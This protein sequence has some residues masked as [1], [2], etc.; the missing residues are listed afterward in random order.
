MLRPALFALLTLAPAAALVGGRAGLHSVSARSPRSHRPLSHRTRADGL[1]V[2]SRPVQS[3][4]ARGASQGDETTGWF[5]DA[6]NRYV[7]LRP[8]GRRNDLT[9]WAA[10]TPGTA[11][12]ILISSTFCL[13][14]AVP[15]ILANPAVLIRLIEISELSRM[16]YTPF[17]FFEATG[18]LFY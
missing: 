5:T 18:R 3:L 11:R 17:E 6:W 15:S 9:G 10:R 4:V 7:L 16:G 13:I 8:E 1:L 2:P 14:V 12:T